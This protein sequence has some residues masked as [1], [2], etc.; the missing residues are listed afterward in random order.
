MS[1]VSILV[2]A[3]LVVFVIVR[4]FTGQPVRANAFVLPLGITVWGLFQL[5]GTHVGGVDLAFLAI[6]ALLALAVGAARGATIH[7]YRRNGYLWQRY[8]WSTLAVWIGAVLLRA[9][10]VGGG[11][12]AGVHVATKG[13]AFVLGVSLV[14]ESAL[15]SWRA[16]RSGVPLAPDRRRLTV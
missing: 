11:N 14:A 6:E 13:L 3:A 4:R 5:R 9:G 7:I 10:L 1:F 15:V 8:R 16:V 2:A 12:L